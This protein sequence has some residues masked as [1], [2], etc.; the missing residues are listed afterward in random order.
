MRRYFSNYDKIHLFQKNQN[1]IDCHFKFVQRSQWLGQFEDLDIDGL[2][3]EN[4]SQFG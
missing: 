2:N 3:I 1:S 4:S